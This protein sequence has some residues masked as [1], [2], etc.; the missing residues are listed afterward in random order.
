[1]CRGGLTDWTW[2][3]SS[4]HWRLPC[5]AGSPEVAENRRWRGPVKGHS[6][7]KAP[8]QT[9]KLASSLSQRRPLRVVVR[10]SRKPVDGCEAGSGTSSSAGNAV[11]AY[12]EHYQMAAGGATLRFH[13]EGT[14]ACGDEAVF[15]SFGHFLT[16][17][18]PSAE[19]AGLDS[20]RDAIPS[21]GGKMPRS[22]TASASTT[23]ATSGP[24]DHWS[25][26]RS[27]P[28]GSVRPA[29]ALR[30]LPP[31]WES[32]NFIVHRLSLGSLSH[33]FP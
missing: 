23:S 26:C 32:V 16:S 19:V 7:E 18:R 15:I 6:L 11:Q 20:I 24:T 33:A 31:L 9:E 22:S 29:G 2:S 10:S 28:V 21:H 1:M 4:I 17:R 5:G 12:A 25:V 13:D 8:I 14:S 27:A 30:V 3:C